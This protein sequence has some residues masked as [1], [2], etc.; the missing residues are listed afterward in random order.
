MCIRDRE[1]GP[2]PANA[3]DIINFIRNKKLFCIIPDAKESLTFNDSNSHI[4]NKRVPN[5]RVLSES[6]INCLNKAIEKY[7]S[8]SFNELKEA[9]HDSSYYSVEPGG[10]IPIENIVGSFKNGKALL[11]QL[12]G[13]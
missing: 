13:E 11:E 10:M 12:R 6:E 4:Y 5:K 1:Y 9:S 8:I 3:Y 2:V 7:G